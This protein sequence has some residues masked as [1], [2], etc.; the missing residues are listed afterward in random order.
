M[1][2]TRTYTF[3]DCEIAVTDGELL[4]VGNNGYTGRCEISLVEA[5]NPDGP[6]TERVDRF[7]KLVERDP[8]RFTVAG[9]YDDEGVWQ[10]D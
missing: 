4:Y 10:D 9:D 3:R 2:E 7:V 8:T 6:D 5:G 1:T